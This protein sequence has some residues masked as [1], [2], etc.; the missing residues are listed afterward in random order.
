MY[1]WLLQDFRLLEKR[2]RQ[3][4]TDDAANDSTAVFSGLGAEHKI[5]LMSNGEVELIPQSVF[6]FVE[7]QALKLSEAKAVVRGNSSLKL[8]GLGSLY[9]AAA[10]VSSALQENV[11]RTSAVE[12]PQFVTLLTVTL[13]CVFGTLQIKVAGTER[14]APWHH[15]LCLSVFSFS[16]LFL[17]NTAAKYMD[18]STRIVFKSAKIILVMLFSVAVVGKTYALSQWMA[19]GTL[20]VGII[21]FSLGDSVQELQF[22]SKGLPLTSLAVC[23]D[24]FTG[25]FEEK[26][27][28]KRNNP[29]SVHDVICHSSFLSSLIGL[30]SL[31]NSTRH[32]LSGVRY[33]EE[34]PSLL[35][36]VMVSS[37]FSYI[38]LCLVLLII[39]VYGAA[40]AEVVK[41]FRRLLTIMIS[42]V[43]FDKR[44]S[45]MHICG[46]CAILIST[47]ISVMSIL[48][49]ERETRYHDPE[50]DSR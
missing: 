10:S 37:C 44:V 12:Y 32:T 48:E 4:S 5:F 42:F 21:F 45:I 18:Y 16:G 9:V 28:F 19:A 11:L 14:R 7:N 17:T 27:F 15:Y 8:V 6:S 34:H 13:H 29:C 41:C 22:Q 31:A 30:A 26:V 1:A 25:S 2:V 35:L 38:S 49:R 40:Q 43:A 50:T 46:F 33:F 36:K 24:A 47:L 20:V 39:A 23:I 3:E